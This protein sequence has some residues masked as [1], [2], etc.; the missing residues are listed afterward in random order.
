MPSQ[1]LRR[2]FGLREAVVLNMISRRSFG[3]SETIMFTIPCRYYGFSHA[4]LQA[5]STCTERSRTSRDKQVG[6]RLALIF[7][8]QDAG[9]VAAGA[10]VRLP[11]FLPVE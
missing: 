4:S 5:V 8:K 11:G 9:A 10:E 3:L 1:A 6:R 2:C 7:P